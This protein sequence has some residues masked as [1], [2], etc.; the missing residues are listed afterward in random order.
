MLRNSLL[1]VSASLI[2]L[3]ALSGCATRVILVP[4]GEPVRLS[5]SVKSRVW[6]IDSKG[7]S[8]K[9]QNR[10]TIPAGWYALPDAKP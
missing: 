4:D 7:N 5:E 9:S 10:V 3:L 6:V 1:F 2:A 8:V